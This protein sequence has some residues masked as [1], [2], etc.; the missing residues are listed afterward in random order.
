MKTIVEWMEKYSQEIAG[1][2][3]S[4]PLLPQFDLLSDDWIKEIFIE[5]NPMAKNVS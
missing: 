4:H 5:A 3:T 2:D 1:M